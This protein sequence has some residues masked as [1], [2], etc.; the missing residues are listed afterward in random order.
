MV[1]CG[2]ALYIWTLYLAQG[3]TVFAV[4]RQVIEGLQ[5]SGKSEVLETVRVTL[6][7][8]KATFMP[9][10]SS[11]NLDGHTVRETVRQTEIV[12][13]VGKIDI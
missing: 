9:L 2:V 7:L 6:Q 5:A 3:C 10:S 11:L 1:V 8:L 4:H 12:Q 13:T